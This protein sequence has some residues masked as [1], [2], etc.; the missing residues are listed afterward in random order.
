[1]KMKKY[2]IPTIALNDKKRPGMTKRRK[3][4]WIPNR[5]GDDIGCTFEDNS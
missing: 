2:W 4:E 3:K 5:V 1:M